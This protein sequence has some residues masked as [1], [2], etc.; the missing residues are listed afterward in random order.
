MQCASGSDTHNAPLHWSFAGRGVPDLLTD[1]HRM[2][3][4]NEPR[5]II[6]GRCNRH[7]RH[8]H[9]GTRA[10]AALGQ[11]NA[12]NAGG[13]FSVFV[14]ELVK[15]AHPIKEEGFRM[16]RLDAQILLHHRGVLFQSLVL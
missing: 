8:H 10:L 11:R 12:K 4:L 5:Q 15:V 1:G 6:L 2:P 7:T 14:E 9:R 13:L 3:R 16:V